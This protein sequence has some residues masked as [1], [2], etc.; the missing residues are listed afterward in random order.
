MCVGI[1]CSSLQ[2]PLLIS[3][4]C[5]AQRLFSLIASG[6]LVSSFVFLWAVVATAP[7]RPR[8][9]QPDGVTSLYCSAATSNRLI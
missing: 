8:L 1:I 2:T 9:S 7:L 3:W 4:F 6:V 5:F